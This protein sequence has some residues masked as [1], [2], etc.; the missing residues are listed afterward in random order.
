MNN[1]YPKSSVTFPP[2]SQLRTLSN[3]QTRCWPSHELL[4]SLQ[5]HWTG[6]E[7]LVKLLKRA[8]GGDLGVEWVG[9]EPRFGSIPGL[10]ME[11]QP[12]MS[13]ALYRFPQILLSTPHWSSPIWSI[14]P[15]SSIFLAIQLCH[16]WSISFT[17]NQT[18]QQILLIFPS[19]LSQ[20]PTTSHWLHSTT[21]SK[22]QSS[23]N[24]LNWPHCST[25]A[26][27][28]SILNRAAR[29]IS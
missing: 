1:N 11:E 22:P 14:N 10:A 17:P 29:V 12:E 9:R 28:P 21:Y 18:H 24:S 6:W 15:Y 2:G 4:M 3:L 27:L 23:D 20:N 7:D 13:R 25:L 16:A 8:W 26:S 19:E 5:G